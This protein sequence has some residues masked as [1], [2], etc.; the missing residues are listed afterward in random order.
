[1]PR[2]MRKL[3]IAV[4]VVQS[5]H[6]VEH[7]VQLY[8]TYVLHL[9]S[10][11]ALGLLGYIVDFHKTAEWLHLFFNLFLLTALLW[12]LPDVRASIAGRARRNAFV[13]LAC[14][15]EMWHIIEH[16]SIAGHLIANGGGCPCPG[17]LTFAPDVI[18]HF[19][20]NALVLIGIVAVARPI[21][22]IRAHPSREAE[23]FA[24]ASVGGS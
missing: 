4:L 2:S 16:M 19:I 21:L 17:V 20:Y 14:G 7:V 1:M 12:L 9:P 3:F 11:R 24:L 13:V 15:V 23:R 5:A 8:Q 18:L 10:D 22:A 6:M